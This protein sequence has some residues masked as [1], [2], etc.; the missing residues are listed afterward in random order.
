MKIL[1]SDYPS[2]F[3]AIRLAYGRPEY[4]VE[5]TDKD[6]EKINKSLD[7]AMQKAASHE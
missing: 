5:L 1:E 6:K 3:H 2:L 4:E 7:R